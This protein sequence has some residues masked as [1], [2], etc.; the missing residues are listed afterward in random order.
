MALD[1]V[2]TFEFRLARDLG[3]T[4]TQLREMP[5]A[6]YVQWRAFYTWEY[7]MQDLANQTAG[8]GR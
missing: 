2:D 8:H 6:E 3:V 5:Q 7:A 1:E 4:L